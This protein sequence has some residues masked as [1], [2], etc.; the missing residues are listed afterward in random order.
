VVVSL[1]LNPIDALCI[2]IATVFVEVQSVQVAM[3]A[4]VIPK[5]NPDS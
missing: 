4:G 5:S 3:M 1:P 2:G